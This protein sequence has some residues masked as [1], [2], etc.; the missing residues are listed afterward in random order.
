MGK[1]AFKRYPFVGVGGYA[2]SRNGF[3]PGS[4]QLGPFWVIKVLDR[5]SR[6]KSWTKL[7]VL[8]LLSSGNHGFHLILRVK[9]AN[10]RTLVR[11]RRNIGIRSAWNRY[12]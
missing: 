12:I 5:I 10:F 11:P 2:S 9:Y 7:P 4:L 8:P 6:S 3:V 1:E